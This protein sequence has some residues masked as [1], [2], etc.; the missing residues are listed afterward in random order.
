MARQNDSL[1][2]EVLSE[3]EWERR[4]LLPEARKDVVPATPKRRLDLAH[5]WRSRL[6]TTILVAL[7]L[8]GSG[9]YVIWRQA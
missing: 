7:V 2:W 8:T 3:E 6:W 1:E 4:N 9:L 5:L